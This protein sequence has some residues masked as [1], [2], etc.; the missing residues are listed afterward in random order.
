ML[1]LNHP[2]TQYIMEAS[3][4]LTRIN[5]SCRKYILENFEERQV[6]FLAMKTECDLLNDYSAIHFSE[7]KEVIAKLVEKTKSEI[8]KLEKINQITEEGCCTVCN[9]K[10]KT[11][12]TLVKDKELR[13][14]TICLEC[15]TPIYRLLNE[16]EVPTGVMWI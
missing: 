15:P 3:G 1:D 9:S 12:D 7:I 13:Y 8:E 16:L 11:I 2:A 6:T 4:F 5:L 14:M 10:L